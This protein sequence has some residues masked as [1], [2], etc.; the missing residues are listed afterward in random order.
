MIEKVILVDLDDN[1]IGEAEKLDAHQQDLLHRAFS[2]FIFDK[3]NRLLIQQRAQ[4]KYHSGSL[5][6][7][8]C[9]GHP[10]PGEETLAAA[11][12]RLYEEINFDCPLQQITKFIYHAQ[13]DNNLTEHEIDNVFVG[14]YDGPVNPNPIEIMNYEWKKIG[15]LK[16]ELQLTPENFTEWFKICFD[17][18]IG[19][20]ED[21]SS[22]YRT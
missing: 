9:C 16:N 21:D 10:R 5:W 18:V 19:L 20:F 2:I 1:P 14:I 13:L 11:H 3:E 4:D 7:N 6:T 22:L 15:Q 8:T 17:D 12:R